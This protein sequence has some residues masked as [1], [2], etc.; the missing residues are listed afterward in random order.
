MMTEK[1]ELYHCGEEHEKTKP[2]PCP[3]LAEIHDD[4]ETFC[5]CCKECEDEC[6]GDI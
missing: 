5:T 2:H 4:E 3:Y 6:R 1:E